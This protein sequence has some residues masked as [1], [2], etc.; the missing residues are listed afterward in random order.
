MSKIAIL[1]NF[2]EP[3]QGSGCSVPGCPHPHEARGF[4]N[5]HYIQWRKFGEIKRATLM[6]DANRFVRDEGFYRIELLDIKGNLVGEA[7]IDLEDYEKCK[8]IKWHLGKQG[9][10]QNITKRIKLQHAVWGS[11]VLLDHINR[12]RLDCRRVNLRL[13]TLGE[14]NTNKSKQRNN[15]SGYIGVSWHKRAKKWMAHVKSNGHDYYLGLFIDPIVAAKV[16]DVE[17]TE[18]FGEFA[19]LNF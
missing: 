11:K 2:M 18:L 7:L 4:C 10:A 19:V 12:D 14:N 9:Y 5:G 8:D 17:A 13:C 6:R 16:R 3:D 1:S 15:T